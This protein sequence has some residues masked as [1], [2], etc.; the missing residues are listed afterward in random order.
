MFKSRQ[1]KSVTIDS[2]IE[3][4]RGSRPRPVSTTKT[5][6]PVRCRGELREKETLFSQSAGREKYGAVQH[7]SGVPTFTT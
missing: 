1:Y 5:I 3:V 4:R 6:Q 2:I 7:S